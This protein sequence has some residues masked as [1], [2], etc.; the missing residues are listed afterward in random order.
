M[1]S[2]ILALLQFCSTCSKS[3]ISSISLLDSWIGADVEVLL[4][5]WWTQWTLQDLN[6]GILW[7]GHG[8]LRFTLR[9]ETK[10]LI[11]YDTLH[12][13]TPTAFSLQKPSPTSQPLSSFF[14][15]EADLASGEIAPQHARGT[16]WTH[17][18]HRVW[19]Y[20]KQECQIHWT[21]KSFRQILDL[22]MFGTH[23]N[24][25]KHSEELIE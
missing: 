18:W 7:F 22:D 14:V 6:I 8:C 17:L 4:S 21:Q 5:P 20:S 19:D 10:K 13:I 1:T 15:T 9:T 23:R 3:S 24:E 11:N 2:F 16:K 12:W 25:D